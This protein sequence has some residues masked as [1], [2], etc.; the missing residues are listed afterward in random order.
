MHV[1]RK[2]AVCSVLASYLFANTVASSFHDHGD[3]CGH[4]AAVLHQ[5][6]DCNKPDVRGDR[7]MHCC[8][9]HHSHGHKQALGTCQNPQPSRDPAKE[10]HDG[11]QHDPQH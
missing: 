1:F 8:H 2:I 6:T 10:Q 5:K 11:G 4:S 3:C 7:G 9:H